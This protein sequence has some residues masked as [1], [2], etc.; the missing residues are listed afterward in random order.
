MYIYIYTYI[1][2]SF[3][4]LNQVQTAEFKKSYALRGALSGLIVGIIALMD[5]SLH[6]LKNV[7][8]SV[9]LVVC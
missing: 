8:T 3:L 6:I 2:A 4:Y 9:L 1:Y 5:T 7:S